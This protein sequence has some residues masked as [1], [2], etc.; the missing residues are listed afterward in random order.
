MMSAVMKLPGARWLWSYFVYFMEVHRGWFV[1][2][3]VL[4]FSILFDIFFAVRSTLIQKFYN[5]PELHEK[6]VQ[7][8]CAQI[9]AWKASGSGKQL[10]SA[11]GG[12]QST[13]LGFRT[14]KKHCQQISVNL[15]DILDYIE[16][17]PRAAGKATVRVEPMCS[18]GQI[19][20]FLV[21]KG[22]SLPV[23]PELDDLTVGGLY[24]GVGIETSSH[25]YGLFNDCVVEAE[26]VDASGEVVKCSPTE[27][28]D[29]FDALPWS[30]GTLGFLVSL[31]IQLVPIQPYVRIEYHPCHSLKEGTRLL[32]DFS[33][34]GERDGDD[35]P[36][37]VEALQ[38]SLETMVVMPASFASAEEAAKGNKNSIG[39]WYK[40][41]FYKHVETFLFAASGSGPYVEY[42]PLR[43]YYHRHTKSIF[44]E[45]EQIMPFGNHPVFRFLLGWAVPPKVSFLKLTQTD[46]IKEMYENAHVVQ[47][48]LVPMSKFEEAIQKFDTEY[49]V[50]PLWICPYRAY[51]Y[52]EKIGRTNID[53]RCF[54]RQPLDSK[55][56]KAY[57]QR[58]PKDQGLKYEMYV[59]IGAYGVPQD[60]IDKKPF[61]CVKTARVVEEYVASV[62]GFQMLY[63]DSYLS[64]A[65]FREMFD[66]EHYDA[67]KK[68]IDPDNGFPQIY[69]KVCKK[70]LQ[71]WGKGDQ[72]DKKTK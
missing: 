7:N 51:D 38:Y 28:R 64:R 69:D 30:Y 47:D 12:W 57:L 16:S 31:T 50:Y 10:C 11:R 25:K 40:P 39:L 26:I 52:A 65:E 33:E 53:H 55:S 60:V 62:H 4:P 19:S 59:D 72:K 46:A 21:P 8:V 70:G 24:M 6:R 43:D 48:M 18:M 44:W 54:L 15:Y 36:D 66:H 3:F 63:A 5:A 58:F 27:N 67:M 17:D 14:Y 23:L 37:F 68:V 29:L 2:F 32:R 20:H 45:M 41:W 34:G 22:K 35:I 49:K 1:L 71:L 56:G 9:K 42:I 61:S 13:S